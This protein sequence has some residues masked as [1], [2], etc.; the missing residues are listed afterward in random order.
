[1]LLERPFRGSQPFNDDGLPAAVYPPIALYLSETIV[2][3]THKTI[4]KITHKTIVKIT[5]ETIV[6]ITHDYSNIT[7][8]TIVKITSKIIPK[9]PHEAGCHSFTKIQGNLFLIS[10]MRFGIPHTSHTYSSNPF[11]A[12]PPTPPAQSGKNN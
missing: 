8:K 11:V 3:I 10:H 1:M 4:V 6:K 7:S 2:K 12:N 5:H 9:Y